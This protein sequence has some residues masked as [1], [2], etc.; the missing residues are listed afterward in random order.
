MYTMGERV[1]WLRKKRGMT[2]EE[3]AF[4]LGYQS[5]SSISKIESGEDEIPKDRV[6][7]FC[8][9]LRVSEAWLMYGKRPE[10]RK[11]PVNASSAIPG[12]RASG[13]GLPY[14]LYTAGVCLQGNFGGWACCVIE[15]KNGGIETHSGCEKDATEEKMKTMAIL[16]GLQCLPDICDVRVYSDSRS[17]LACLDDKRSAKMS[18]DRLYRMLTRAAKGKRISGVHVRTG[19][20]EHLNENCRKIARRNAGMLQQNQERSR[21]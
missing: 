16:Q 2:Q 7:A 12:S 3:L 10:G 1:R 8:K 9:A 18:E 5:R 15:T 17:A 14:L 19:T 20:E 4:E 13:Y 11:T 6:F 21:G